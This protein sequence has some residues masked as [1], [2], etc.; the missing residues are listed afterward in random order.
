MHPNL[1][2][3]YR[4]RV[5]TL[6]SA[7]S[8]PELSTLAAEALRSLIEGIEIHPGERRGEV[9]VVLPGDPAAL[10]E[11]AEAQKRPDIGS[12]IRALCGVMGNRCKSPGMGGR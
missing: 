6:E 2:A 5:E 11:A 1:P 8:D 9:S 7:L 3:L 12:D 4:R 10:L